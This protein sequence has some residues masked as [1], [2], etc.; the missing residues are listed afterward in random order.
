M[1][2]TE[3]SPWPIYSGDPESMQLTFQ[4]ND[5]SIQDLTEFYDSYRAQWRRT[6]HNGVAIDVE[7]D[8]SQAA[9]GIL[10]LELTKAQTEAMNGPGVFDIEALMGADTR[11]ILRGSTSWKQDV[12]R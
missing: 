4:N 6:P 9:Q 12:T 8:D 11:T 2:P 3:I 5:G 1:I 7:V 10:R